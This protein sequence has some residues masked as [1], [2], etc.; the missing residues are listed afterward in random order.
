MRQL[1]SNTVPLNM[2]NFLTGIPT[3][4]EIREVVWG[5]KGDKS[6]GPDGFS[7]FFFQNGWSIV[8][9]KLGEAVKSF[10]RDGRLLKQWNVASITLAPKTNNVSKPSDFRPIACCSVIYKI[11]SKILAS[12]LREVVPVLTSQQQ[13][14][15]VKGRNLKDNVM[16]A[17]EI[18][19]NYGRSHIS[20]RF[21]MKIDIHKAY[22]SVRWDF[23]QQVLRVM[24]F[25]VKFID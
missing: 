18:V 5:I 25:P 16:V 19:R 14:G 20:P 3:D 6:P 22:D 7:A 15:F 8:G 9:A 2:E 17:Q 12:R 24:K 21:T 10:F 1:V 23:V 13:S 11:I 4:E